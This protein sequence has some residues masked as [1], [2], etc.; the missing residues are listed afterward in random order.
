[1]IPY[2][3][4]MESLVKTRYFGVDPKKFVP[5]ILYKHTVKGVSQRVSDEKH[6]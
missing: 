1:M 4:G 3:L 5:N 6:L 2:S